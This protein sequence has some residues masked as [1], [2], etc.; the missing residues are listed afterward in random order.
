MINGDALANL[1]TERDDNSDAYA[2]VRRT[3]RKVRD[4]N[5][6][7]DV[8]VDHIFTLM[9]SS[10]NNEILRIGVDVSDDQTV[11][12]QFGDPNDAKNG[13]SKQW[14]NPYAQPESGT[15]GAARWVAGFAPVRDRND[16]L[17]AA[18]GVGVSADAMYTQLRDAILGGVCLL[19]ISTMA[20]FWI[21]YRSTRPLLPQPQGLT[22]VAGHDRANDLSHR[23]AA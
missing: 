21:T 2:L 16:R 22:E 9:R 15:N 11:R 8:Y 20:T 13:L 12:S 3:L 14:E 19:A 18:V 5:R 6:R 17:V 23:H 4:S 7:N 10:A 1:K